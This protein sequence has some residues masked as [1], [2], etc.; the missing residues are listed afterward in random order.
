M[1]D[2]SHS[3]PAQKVTIFS[4]LFIGNLPTYLSNSVSGT[5]ILPNIVYCTN[6][7]FGLA[8]TIKALLFSKYDLITTV[9]TSR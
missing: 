7:A 5:F 8:S 9:P 1:L 4:S 3:N 2:F 6:F